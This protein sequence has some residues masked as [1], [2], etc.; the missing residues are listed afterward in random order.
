MSGSTWYISSSNS[1][2]VPASDVREFSLR[3]QHGCVRSNIGLV[4]SERSKVGVV[5]DVAKRM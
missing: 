2:K 5:G 1:T 4:A 3:G